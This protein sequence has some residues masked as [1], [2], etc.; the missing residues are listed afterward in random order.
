LTVNFN[1]FLETFPTP[2]ENTILVLATPSC[3]Y[4]PLALEIFSHALTAMPVAVPVDQNWFGEWFVDAITEGTKFLSP[5]LLAAGHPELAALSAGAGFIAKNVR[6]Y[7]APPSAGPPARPLKIKAAKSAP[8]KEP[9]LTKEARA[10]K[11][12]EMQKKI[13][14][15]QTEMQGL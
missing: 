9:T 14:M 3:P 7:M 12:R 11:K 8:S 2:A 6:T 5:L 10:K 1:L 13:A 15:M 4:D